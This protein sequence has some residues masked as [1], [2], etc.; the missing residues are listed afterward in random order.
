MY[1]FIICFN[2]NGL[3]PYQ[4]S[5]SVA[6][7]LGLHCLARSQKWNARHKRVFLIWMIQHH[8]FGNIIHYHVHAYLCYLKIWNICRY[9]YLNNI[10]S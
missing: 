1:L 10:G 6:T 9:L 4:T 7:D 8:V 5:H 3:D 2:G